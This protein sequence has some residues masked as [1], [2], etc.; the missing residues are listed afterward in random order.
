[1]I[2]YYFIES[3]IIIQGENKLMNLLQRQYILQEMQLEE[4]SEEIEKTNINNCNLLNNGHQSL[5]QIDIHG[6]CCIV[7]MNKG[8]K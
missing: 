1:M 2:I 3:K 7:I 6:I 4:E 8:G 5:D